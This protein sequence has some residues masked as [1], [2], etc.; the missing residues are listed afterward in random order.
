[1]SDVK[2]TF[3]VIPCYNEETR[4]NSEAFKSYIKQN[5]NVRFLFV[6]DGSSDNTETLLKALS[7]FENMECLSLKTNMGK[8]NAILNGTQHLLSKY[9]E[10]D[11]IGYWDA[12]LATP[13]SEVS[14]FQVS[15]SVDE[16]VLGVFG[17][18]ISRLGSKIERKAIRH[19][20]GRVFATA[21]SFL[22][23]MNVYDTQTGAKI[24]HRSL[25]LEIF[26]EPFRSKWL[27]DIEILFRI[28][29]SIFYELNSEILMELPLKFWK[30]VD[31]SKLKLLDFVKAPIELV[32]LRIRYA[33][34]KK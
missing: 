15:F 2:I 27:F 20:L 22:L 10:V 16:R 19:Y 13:L 33:K 4:L 23:G 32:A 12:D 31:G 30:D 9:P 29:N 7:L 25:A 26:R 28:K 1:M 3:L 18:R 17:S 21:A 14:R 24:F 11:L 6:N 8:A 5:P 34:G